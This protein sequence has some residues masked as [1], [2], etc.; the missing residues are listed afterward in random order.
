MC[1]TE[2]REMVMI[3]L[4]A[5]VSLSKDDKKIYISLSHLMLLSTR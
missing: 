2:M 3:S 5:T 4:W 1:F